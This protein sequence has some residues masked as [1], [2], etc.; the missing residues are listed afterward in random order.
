[1]LRDHAEPVPESC[2]KERAW[3]AVLY[4][5]TKGISKRWLLRQFETHRFYEVPEGKLGK[6][7]QKLEAAFYVSETFMMIEQ[8]ALLIL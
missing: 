1:M 3:G 4:Q 6:L 7:R 2:L 8:M 5:L